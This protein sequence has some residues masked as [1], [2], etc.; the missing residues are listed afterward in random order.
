MIIIDTATPKRSGPGPYIYIKEDRVKKQTLNT[1]DRT[2]SSFD[3]WLH[4]AYHAVSQIVDEVLL[5]VSN[6]R[7]FTRILL[8][9]QKGTRADYIWCDGFNNYLR[10]INF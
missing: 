8:Y 9:I 6:V 5:A 2:K 7:F 3:F 4:Q 1:A 10:N